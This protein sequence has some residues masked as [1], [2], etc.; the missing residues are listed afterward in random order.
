MAEPRIAEHAVDGLFIG[1]TSPRSFTGEAIPD[2]VLF[3]MFEA[4][5]WAPSASNIQPWRLI[6][7]KAGTP[8]WGPL[9]EC[10]M[11]GN[12]IWVAKA[13]ALVAFVAETHRRQGETRTENRTHALDTGAA[14][15]SLALQA[16]MLGW[17]THGMAGF[18]HD[19]AREALRLPA[20]FDVYMFAAVGKR[21]PAAALP[22]E[23][24]AREVPSVRRSMAETVFSGHFPVVG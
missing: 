2:E 7:A 8:E 16:E 14:W 24:A 10:L 5:R 20:D 21:G 18:F 6:Y 11:P 12:Q 1:R 17:A 22:P 19:K 13:S 23:L 4:A 9:F 3:S 15:M